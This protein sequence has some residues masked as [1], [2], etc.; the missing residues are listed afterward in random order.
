[1]KVSVI[2]PVYNEEKT[3]AA[4]LRSILEQTYKNYNVVVVD[5]GSTD[6][7]PGILS[8]HISEKLEVIS[9][10]HKG[11]GAARN[12]AA[13]HADG[14]IYVF[15]DA[16]MTAE[17]TFI[18]ELVAPIVAKKAI[19]TTSHNESVSNWDNVWAQCTNIEQ[20][21]LAGKRHGAIVEKDPVFRAILAS[22]FKKVHGFTPG[23][24]TDDYTLSEKLGAYPVVT[25]APFSHANPDSI[26]EVYRQAVWAAKRTYKLGTF[27]AIVAVVRANPL[28]SLVVGMWRAA[29]HKTPLYIVFKLVYDW[30]TMVGITKYLATGSGEK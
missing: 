7:T 3:I 18:A 12:T 5:D 6:E 1:M 2:I 27:G 4:C 10:N 9:G 24:Y 25:K 13:S 23:G 26:V 16:D 22:E 28:V 19:G 30:G 14:D 29:K 8:Q 11:A 17:P 20:G 15:F 21:W